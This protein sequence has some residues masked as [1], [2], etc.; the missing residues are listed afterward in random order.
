MQLQKQVELATAKIAR[1]TKTGQAFSAV[2]ALSTERY[3]PGFT[4]LVLKRV[5][6]RK[7]VAYDHSERPRFSIVR[8]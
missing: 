4:S 2:G 3:T 7:Q 1:G 5:L 6:E 8:S